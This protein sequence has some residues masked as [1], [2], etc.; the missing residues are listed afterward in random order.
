L[1]LNNSV[2]ISDIDG[3]LL[4]SQGLISDFTHQTLRELMQRGL[5][6][7]VATARSF[8]SAKPA[9][10]GLALSSLA[11]THNGVHIVE[12]K[13][14]E[15]IDG[16]CFT[17]RQYEVVDA[18]FRR[19]GIDFVVYSIL[20]GRE[21]VSFLSTAHNQTIE[22]YT[23]RQKGDPRLRI[24]DDRASLFDGEVFYISCLLEP[25]LLAPLFEEV[26]KIAGLRASFMPDTYRPSYHWLEIM[27][28]EATKESG[29]LRVKELLGAKYLVCFGDNLNDVGM[30]RAADIGV[31][32][33][34][35]Q[36]EAKA[37]AKIV[38]LSNDEDGV[39]RFLL[40][41]FG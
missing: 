13:S 10:K 16:S 1:D 21:R 31:A 2:F 23:I 30:L 41:L 32:V 26:P 3:T 37:A 19:H 20:E 36:P 24:V 38:A 22:H 4:N 17:P 15:I 8:L 6:F 39:A 29:T 5:R 9:L 7:T 35:A 28:A 11:V 27:P 34:N 40:D 18:L 25:E 33:E 14:G 12:P